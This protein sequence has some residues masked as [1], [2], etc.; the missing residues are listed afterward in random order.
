MWLD[1]DS[2]VAGLNTGKSENRRLPESPESPD[3]HAARRVT[4]GVIEVDARRSVKETLSNV[5]LAKPSGHQRMNR[6]AQRAAMPTSGKIVVEVCLLRGGWEP[7]RQ[8]RKRHDH[9]RLLDD[10]GLL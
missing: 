5:S 2:P 6:E 1:G 7:I 4:H 9:V 8:Q 10:L 3:M